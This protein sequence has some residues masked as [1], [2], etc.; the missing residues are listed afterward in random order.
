M[1]LKIHNNDGRTIIAACDENLLGKIFEEKDGRCLDLK[2][3]QS[4]YKGSKITEKDLINALKHFSSV[5]LVGEGVV[6]AALR[7]NI[8]NDEDIKLIKNIPYVQIYTV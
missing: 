5:N 2:T 1:Y 8:I 3:Y 6:K 7:L 4:F